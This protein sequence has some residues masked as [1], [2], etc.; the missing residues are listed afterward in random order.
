MTFSA[1]DHPYLSAL[2]GDD[3]AAG[4]F[5]A[6]AEIAAMLSFEAALAKAEAQWEVIPAPAAAEIVACCRNFRPDMERLRAGID[7]DGV[8]VPELV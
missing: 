6:E 5:S 7:R 3:E 8:V 1:F 4:F 2:V